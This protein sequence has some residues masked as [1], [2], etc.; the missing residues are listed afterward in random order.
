MKKEIVAYK[1][2]IRADIEL[3]NSDIMIIFENYIHEKELQDENYME[4]TIYFTRENG[5][6]VLKIGKNINAPIKQT[7][8]WEE[9]M[10][11]RATIL[12]KS[13][14][15]LY[16]EIFPEDK[17]TGYHKHLWKEKWKRMRDY[18]PY[19]DTFEEILRKNDVILQEK[20]RLY[21]R[22]FGY[23]NIL[24]LNEEELN[25]HQSISNNL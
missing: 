4:T 14:M 11:Y 22:V 16:E 13:R 1:L 12:D 2:L 24:P 15:K 9:Y 10:K 7:I 5:E 21:L 17:I 8:K 25:L 23:E 19:S 18:V 3:K 20:E 6:I